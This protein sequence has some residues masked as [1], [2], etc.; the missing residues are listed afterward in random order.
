MRLHPLSGDRAGQFA[1]TLVHPYRL[2][3]RPNHNP[4]PLG[5]DGGIDAR[6]VTL[7]MIMEVVDYH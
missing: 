1:V 3:F 5:N 4:V 6:Q 2:V 7:I